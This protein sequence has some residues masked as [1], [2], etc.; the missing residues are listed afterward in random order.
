M[1]KNTIITILIV[2]LPLAFWGGMKCQHESNRF[3]QIGKPLFNIVEFTSGKAKENRY[4]VSMT[5][6]LT[7]DHQVTALTQTKPTSE[8][9]MPNPK[10]DYIWR[11]SFTT[12]FHQQFGDTIKIFSVDPPTIPTQ[13]GSGLKIKLESITSSQ[14]DSLQNITNASVKKFDYLPTHNRVDGPATGR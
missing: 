2:L 3:D 14:F 10:T 1:S 13:L 4:L 8:N 7:G 5:W 6:G 9:W 12:V 11:G